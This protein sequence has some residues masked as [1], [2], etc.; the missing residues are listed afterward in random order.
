MKNFFRAVFLQL[1]FLKLL[2][3]SVCSP[4]RFICFVA[5]LLLSAISC[6]TVSIVRQNDSPGSGKSRAKFCYILTT[7]SEASLRA[8]TG[9]S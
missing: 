1:L 7:N 6:P 4:A 5:D 8:R 3:G 9:C 2:P